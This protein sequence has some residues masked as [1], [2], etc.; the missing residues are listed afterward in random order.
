[1]RKPWFFPAFA[2]ASVIALFFVAREVIIE[3]PVLDGMPT[4]PAP[5][6]NEAEAVGPATAAPPPAAPAPAP[7]AQQA[8]AEAPA[9]EPSEGFLRALDE[10]RPKTAG[11]RRRLLE[12][13]AAAL[14]AEPKQDQKEEQKEQRKAEVAAE[15]PADFVPTASGELHDSR[16]PAAPLP[17]KRSVARE[18][19]AT[20]NAGA[21]APAAAPAPMAPVAAPPMGGLSGLSARPAMD[22]PPTP[23]SLRELADHLLESNQPEEAAAVYRTLIARYPKH[24]DVAVWKGRLEKA[25][26]PA[27]R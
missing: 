17:A 13:P 4:S 10:D 22:R 24:E 9:A 27:R 18:S 19:A 8:P 15:A 7:A 25:V 26:R 6:A 20:G 23:E 12:K 1:L 11:P 2:A 5:E 3:R 16:A 14:R 21:G